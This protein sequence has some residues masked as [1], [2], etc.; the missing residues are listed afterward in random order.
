MQLGLLV[1]CCA[2]KYVLDEMKSSIDSWERV[3]LHVGG[4]LGELLVGVV[5][6]VSHDLTAQFDVSLLDDSLGEDVQK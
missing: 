4:E 6:V 1:C 3:S 2:R 5:E